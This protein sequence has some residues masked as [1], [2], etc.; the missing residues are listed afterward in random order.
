M[1]RPNQNHERRFIESYGPKYRIDISNP[2][3]DIGGANVYT[4]YAVTDDGDVSLSGL[5][6][7]GIFRTYND[8]SIEIIA[9][10]KSNPGDIDIVIAGINGDVTITAMGNGSVRIKG[11]NIMIEADEDIDLKAGRNINLKSSSGRISLESNKLDKKALT[12][13]MVDDNFTKSV[14]EGSYVGADFINS[15]GSNFL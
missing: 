14:F 13:N 12:G 11:K 5:T 1:E 6:E 2:K 9:G 8:R 10:S 7:S 15:L 4:Q 3:M